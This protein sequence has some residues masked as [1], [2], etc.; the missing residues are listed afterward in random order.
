LAPRKYPLT[1]ESIDRD[2]A[3]EADWEA[4]RRALA[5]NWL[6]VEPSSVRYTDL[7]KGLAEC[8]RRFGSDKFELRY[9]LRPPKNRVEEWTRDCFQ[10]VLSEAELAARLKADAERP[11]DLEMLTSFHDAYDRQVVHYSAVL[12]KAVVTPSEA[13]AL[14]WKV[15]EQEIDAHIV[16]LDGRLPLWRENLE[17]A[18]DFLDELRVASRAGLVRLGEFEAT[19][20]HWL[21]ALVFRRMTEAWRSCKDIS[22][23]SH[24]S[25]RYL[26]AAR[27]I[28]LFQKHWS[29]RFPTPQSL[30]ERLREEFILA[31]TALNSRASVASTT[32]TEVSDASAAAQ[33]AN[34]LV[35]NESRELVLLGEMYAL[36][37]RAGHIYRLTPNSDWGIDGEIEFKD[38]EGHASGRRV[39]VQLKSGD[40]HLVRRARD[41]EEVHSVKNL[42]H[43]QYWAQQAYPVFL[44][45]RQSN[46]LIRWMD[47]SAYL[48]LNGQSNRKIIFR[49]ELLTVNAVKALA[50]ISLAPPS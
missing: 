38:S 7:L 31:R 12:Q 8:H 16:A 46:G 41:G 15:R 23:R 45:I 4:A 32:P 25:R 17:T 48:K 5:R 13:V 9:N 37:G 14:D 30:S 10:G 36:V 11:I 39:Y 50:D 2:A 20:A 28:D 24:R 21:S 22:E 49:G 1:A 42:R 18:F 43:L 44:V 6:N 47:V 26:Y 35:D 27:T 3:D 34:N 29:A 40:S 33:V 19:S